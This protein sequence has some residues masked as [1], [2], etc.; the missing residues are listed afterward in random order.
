MKDNLSCQCGKTF[1]SAM[2]EAKH[3][4]NFPALCKAKKMPQISHP[5]NPAEKRIR[6]ALD[7]LQEKDPDAWHTAGAV[8]REAQ[9]DAV[10]AMGWLG[11]CTRR[12][13]DFI[14]R[15]LI[16]AYKFYRKVN[17]NAD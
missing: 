9:C 6:D 2:S 5:N 3:R 16:G 4:H 11:Y 1:R 13:R 12:Q 14:E 15:K 8:S 7:R 10:T 17:K